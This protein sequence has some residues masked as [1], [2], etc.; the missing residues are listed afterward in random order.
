[1][2]SEMCIRD[3]IYTVGGRVTMNSCI[4]VCMH[5]CVQVLFDYKGIYTSIR[6]TFLL[7]IIYFIISSNSG[8][9]NPDAQRRAATSHE[10]TSQ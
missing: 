6:H 8:Q 1:M 2:G 3:S 4:C 5:A 9:P 10:G 7:I